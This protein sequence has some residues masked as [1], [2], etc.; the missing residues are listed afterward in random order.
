[1][2]LSELLARGQGASAGP[3]VGD[4]DDVA[5]KKPSI[6]DLIA[7]AAPKKDTGPSA[8]MAG[9]GGGFDEDV[10]LAPTRAPSAAERFLSSERQK[11]E[12]LPGKLGALG[13]NAVDA[14]TLGG[15]SRLRNGAYGVVDAVAGTNAEAAARANDEGFNAAHPFAAGLAKGVGYAAPIGATSLIAKGVT[16]AGGAAARAAPQVLKDF[17]VTNPLTVG[18]AKHAATGAAVT[19]LSALGEEVTAG[20]PISEA[21]P[22]AGNAAIAGGA[23]GAA[24]GTVADAILKSGPRIT[25]AAQDRVVKTAV[26]DIVGNKK[27]GKAIDTDVKK[28]A[29]AI[30]PIRAELATPEGLAIADTARYEPEEGLQLVR[31]KVKEITQER[32]PDYQLV[33]KATGS[34]GVRAGDFVKHL[35]DS[36]DALEATGKGKDAQIAGQLRHRV[37]LLKRARDWGGGSQ[38]PIDPNAPFNED[39]T[40]GQYLDLMTKAGHRDQALVDLAKSQPAKGWNPDVIVPTEKLRNVVT[41]MQSTAYDNLGGINGTNAFKKA[42]EVAHVGEDFLNQHLD[43]AAST[44]AKAAEAVERIRAMNK[45]VNAYKTIETALE[46]RSDKRAAAEVREMS[47]NDKSDIAHG[48]AL[49]TMHPKAAAAGFLAKKVVPPALDAIDRGA[50][51]AL[52][53]RSSLGGAV[54][55]AAVARL[56]QAGRSGATREKLEAMAQEQGVPSEIAANIAAQNGL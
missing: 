51:R 45:R 26:G 40:N 56:I 39:Y 49:L 41:D 28:M 23:A 27:T 36:A 42:V 25:K 12:E 43:Q 2:D 11:A 30:E 37:E 32:A 8:F 35:E 33:D 34:G 13:T 48:A 53:G 21:L 47:E 44:D 46:T 10:E 14:A 18:L 29:R 20:V 54:S 5:T 15:Y 1:M 3:T 19:G 22:D 38:A 7:R 50:S 6:S 31:N 24:L 17:A 9:R 4:E 55:P 52:A 16:T